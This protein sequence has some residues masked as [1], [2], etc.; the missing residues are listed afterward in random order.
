MTDGDE[1]PVVR[2][3]RENKAGVSNLLDI[4]SAVSGKTIAE[5]EAEFEGKMYGHLKTEVAE[6][7]SALLTDLQERYNH[8]RQDEALLEKSS[9][10][11]RKKLEYEQEKHLKK[12]I[13]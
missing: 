9:E 4:L 2:Y 1:P 10:K 13:N 5:L 11:G 3:D 7:V 8:F 6:Q 12:C